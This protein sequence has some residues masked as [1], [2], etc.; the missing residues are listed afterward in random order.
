MVNEN[1]VFNQSVPVR[2][3]LGSEELVVC[4][5]SDKEF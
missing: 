1:S 2:K 4:R 3:S 5:G